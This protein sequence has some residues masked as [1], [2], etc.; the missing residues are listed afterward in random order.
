MRVLVTGADGFIGKNILL[1]LFEVS[2]IEI[3]CFTRDN[4]PTE[5][6]SLLEGVDFIIHLAGVN[7]PDNSNE[8]M[9]GNADL[10][11]KLA[12]AII[13]SG[14]K[15]PLVYASSIQASLDNPYGV[16]KRMAEDSL[17]ALRR[18]HHIPV[19][20]FR[21]PNVFGKWARPNYNSAVATFC[22]NI[23]HELPIQINDPE[24]SIDLVY[25]DDV[26][27]R[28]ILMM[29]EGDLESEF[30]D[31][32]PIYKITV[33]DLAN[34]IYKFRNS[35][36]SMTTESVGHGLMRALYATYLS[37]ISK[38]SFTYK[39]PSHEDDRGVFVEMLKTHDAGQF[40]YF[41]A[42]PGITRGGHYHHSKSEKFLVVKG[43]A[44]FRFKHM[45]TEECHELVT[46]GDK[47][48]IVETIPGWAH[49]ITNVGSDEMI[50]MLWAN[51]IFSHEKPDTYASPTL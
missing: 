35:R 5:F 19:T 20:V 46:T 39:L 28:I 8:F 10:S 30:S 48:E 22:H 15:A 41:T 32:S 17:L 24:A 43:T 11:E 27:E 31:I 14:C 25:I 37:Y 33:G 45:I 23:A 29:R 21:L 1:H 44:C 49:D 12:Q 38:D 16:S 2:D 51:E 40:S 34:Q 50:V 36:E 26:V 3:V 47:P 42:H 13:S 18:K 9:Q 4:S 7:R 6:P